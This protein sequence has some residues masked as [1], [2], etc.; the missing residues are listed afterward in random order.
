MNDF[1]IDI[2]KVEEWQMLNDKNEL[3]RLFA[4]AQSTV[5]NGARVLLMRKSTSGKSEMFDEIDTLDD[6]EK[7]RAT[8]MK[9]VV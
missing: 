2:S 9:Y 4:K 5:V 6:L 3:D 1:V 8:V 7:Y